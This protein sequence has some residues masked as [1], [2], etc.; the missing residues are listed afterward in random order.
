MEITLD[1]SEI[2]LWKMVDVRGYGNVILG[3]GIRLNFIKDNID[4]GN[5]SLA[6]KNIETLIESHSSLIDRY[7]KIDLSRLD[8]RFPVEI[9]TE[10][11][12]ETLPRLRGLYQSLKDL[13]KRD[14]KSQKSEIILKIEECNVVLDHMDKLK[15]DVA[16]NVRYNQFR[17]LHLRDNEYNKGYFQ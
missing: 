14:N 11:Q 10:L 3:Y 16:E 7:D 12:Q 15:R 5:Y 2:E 9:I 13:I 1:Q 8:N 17:E 4:K 6:I